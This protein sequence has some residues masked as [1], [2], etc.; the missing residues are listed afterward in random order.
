MEERTTLIESLL[1]KAET[2]A[3]T[4]ADL[5]KLKFI[6]KSADLLSTLAERFIF[7][8]AFSLITIM[9]SLGLALWIG[10]LMG[11]MYFGF[12][13]VALFYILITGF[14]YYFRKSFI[15]TPLNNAIIAEMLKEKSKYGKDQ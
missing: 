12:I 8:K 15:K 1:E 9:I 6:D 10:E 11:K 5:Y 4:N 7:V 13:T 14:V 3:K 2:Y